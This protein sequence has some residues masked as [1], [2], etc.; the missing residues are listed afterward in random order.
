MLR[1]YHLL[2]LTTAN[3]A[4]QAE[5]FEKLIISNNH[6][7][8]G[9]VSPRD[10]DLKITPDKDNLVFEGFQ[11]SNMGGVVSDLTALEGSY[12][13]TDDQNFAIVKT[14]QLGIQFSYDWD[15]FGLRLTESGSVRIKSIQLVFSNF[16]LGIAW[17]A[18]NEGA[19]HTNKSTRHQN[20]EK[21][22]EEFYILSTYGN[23]LAHLRAATTL[24]DHADLVDAVYKNLGDAT[25]R[26]KVTA[27]ARGGLAE[28]VA[29]V[30]VV[31]TDTGLRVTSGVFEVTGAKA[32]ATKVGLDRFWRDIRTHSLHD[33][34]AYKNRE[35]GRYHLVGENPYAD[36]VYLK[37]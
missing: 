29:S 31:T 12:N 27:Q 3:S 25:T 6:F 8:G 21:A 33:P 15:N 5:R 13:D 26:A 22:Q 9:A 28:W 4:E 36:V 7:V 1:V 14:D 35:L 30:K 11:F 18:L 32:A 2:W 10:N 17:R 34:V 23:F 37:A 19:A 20:K 24:A 16:Y